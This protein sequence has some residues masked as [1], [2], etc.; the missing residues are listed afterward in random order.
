[1]ARPEEK[2]QAML[3][4]WVKMRDQGENY[5]Q[6]QA[7]KRRP[8]LASLCEHLHD[9]EKWRRQIIREISN[10]ISKI[11][12][13]GLGEHAI[14]DLNDTINKSMREKY[15]WNKRIIELGGVDY[16]RIERLQQ[17]EESDGTG[18]S[19]GLK[20]SSGYRY[21]GAAK[22]LPGVKELFARNA[23]KI[24]KRRRGDVYK[25]ITPDYYGLRDDEDGVLLELEEKASK[26]RRE[27]L[28]ILRKEFRTIYKGKEQ[29]F[30]SD[31]EE[32]EQG[33]GGIL[34]AEDA[35]AAHV[36]IPTQEIVERTILEQK[37]KELLDSL[38]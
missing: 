32:E 35:V 21:F 18:G 10:N 17:L 33:S 12:N 2:A 36:A 3:N 16:N 30:E 14:R 7:S 24:T 4:K 9:A 22:E 26:K 19:M 1:M 28:D 31:D 25:Y 13:K 27:K 29:E 20:G 11:Q 38:F 23:V 6:I 8:Y 37:K 34:G 5:A 15:H